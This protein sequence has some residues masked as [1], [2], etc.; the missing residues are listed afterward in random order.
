MKSKNKKNQTFVYE[1]L[2]FPIKLI[3][4]PMRKTLGKWVIDL[5]MNK[6]QVAVLRTLIY[7]PAP[8]TGDELKFIR[9]YL[10]LSMAEFGKVFGITHVAVVKWESGQRNISPPMEICIRLYILEQL[11]ARDKEFRNLYNTIKLEMLSKHKTEK[12]HPLV[13]DMTDDF[14]IAL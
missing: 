5:D 1:G 9:K 7:K 13:I 12:I 3:N 6:L 4:A 14:K 8:L 11:H 10:Y 2:G